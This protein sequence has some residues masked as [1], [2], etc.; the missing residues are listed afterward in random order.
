MR[1]VIFGAG[2]VGRGFIAQ[3]CCESGYE[4]VFVD[5]NATL[6]EAIETHK[7][8]TIDMVS[9]AGTQSVRIENIAGV[10]GKDTGAVAD[11]VAQADLIATAVGVNAL[12]HIA[13]GLAAGLEKRFHQRALAVNIIIC[14]N[15]L[16][17]NHYLQSLVQNELPENLW[18]CLA[19]V[20]F[21][22]ASIGRMVPAA[23]NEGNPLFIAVEPYQELPVDG[24]AL[25]TP[26]P[27]LSGMKPYA[28]FGFHIQRK[29]FIHN[30]GH[31][32]C[33]YLGAA[34]GYATIWEAIL[35]PWV[36]LC[37]LY[38]M[39]QA[40]LALAAEHG[41]DMKALTAHAHDLVYRFAN[42]AL[43]DDV[44]RVGR[45]T[46][47]KLGKDDRLA[48]ALRLCAK[49]KLPGSFMELGIAAGLRFPSQDDGTLKTTA[50]LNEAGLDAFLGEH[51]GL[52]DMPQS[53][54]QI[55]QFLNMLENGETLQALFQTAV[56]RERTG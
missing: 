11:A 46:F 22:E 29:L 49:H 26:I 23:H 8:Y 18:P 13:K 30:M 53:R 47:R 43:G 45:D 28:P 52:H 19:Q 7:G 54:T 15:M 55:R 27:T 12:P 6:L 2:N 37:C 4:V 35:N 41:A 51:C 42:K 39:E 40:S 34:F 36:H 10:N 50:M 24:A 31:C 14:E 3:L 48:G 17:A 21:V 25:R 32:L 20:G 38:A 9:N 5:V 56:E 16:N 1:A 44:A 33:A